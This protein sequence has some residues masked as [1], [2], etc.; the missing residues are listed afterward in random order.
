MGFSGIHRRSMKA[1]LALLF[2]WLK[3]NWIWY[4]AP[5]EKKFIKGKGLI[6]YTKRMCGHDWAFAQYIGKNKIAY[7]P[8]VKQQ[9][10]E[11]W[12]V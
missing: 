9:C 6:F 5:V 12:R 10:W 7:F 3:F 4:R 11:A 8:K 1:K 2:R